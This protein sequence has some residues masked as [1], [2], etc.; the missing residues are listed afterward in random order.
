MADKIGVYF[1][2]SSL[3]GV[4]DIQRLCDGV[5]KNGVIAAP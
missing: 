3:G 5:L 1:D 2:E 4:L